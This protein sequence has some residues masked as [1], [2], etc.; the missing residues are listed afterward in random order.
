MNCVDEQKDYVDIVIINHNTANYLAS[1]LDSIRKYS[2]YPYQVTVVDNGSTDHSLALLAQY[3]WVKTIANKTNQGYAR[4]CNQG[5][6]GN[7][8]PFILLLN[9][10][11][12][13]T[14]NWLSPMVQCMQSNPLN[15][16][17]GNR[18]I[19]AEGQ[20]AGAGVIGDYPFQYRGWGLP[21]RQDLYDREEEVISISGACMMIKREL[22]PV[23]HLL[24]E[25]YFFYFEDTDYCYQARAKGYRVVYC[26]ASTVFH[27]C[28]TS[29]LKDKLRLRY[30]LAAKKLFEHKW[31]LGAFKKKGGKTVEPD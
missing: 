6:N 18:Q 1:C 5:I 28:D 31:G 8:G 4:A 3:N 25:R 29:P 10:D 13:V 2:D 17:V 12:E 22:L 16:V 24:D 15:G 26:P 9:S 19:N 21:F 27:Y 20:L 14:P 11:V 7:T 30:Y 23:L